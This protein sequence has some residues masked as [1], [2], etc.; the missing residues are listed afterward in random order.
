RNG[1]V[2]Q[3]KPKVYALWQ[4]ARTTVKGER[5]I[6]EA[7]FHSSHRIVSLLYI[8]RDSLGY[9]FNRT[10]LKTIFDRLVIFRENASSPFVS[11]IVRYHP[12]R[13]YLEKHNYDMS[14]LHLYGLGDYTGYL[15]YLTTTGSR[16]AIIRVVNGR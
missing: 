6:V 4:K 7:P 5:Q 9:R 10:M 14:H 15:E 16:K 13:P 3:P 2:P 11:K 1:L 12:D 8:S